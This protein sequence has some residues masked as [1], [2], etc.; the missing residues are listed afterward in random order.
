MQPLVQAVLTSW[1]IPPAA[2]FVILFTAATY[3][4]GAWLLRRA[5]YPFLPAWRIAMFLLGLFMLW[6]ALASPFDTF[7]SFF[8][9]AHMSQHMTLMMI[10]PPLL[11]LGEP[12]IPIVRG[13]PRFAARE[14][15]GPFLNW[16]LAGSI[17]KFLT[18]PGT[19]LILMGAVMFIWHVPAPYELAVRSGA[20]HE[21]EHACFFFVSIIFW[22]PVV[23]P[24]PSHPQWPRWAMVPYLVVADILNTILSAIL[25]FSEH[26]LYPSYGAGPRLFGVSAL[27]DQ[28]ASGAVM[29]TVGSFA[30]LIPAAL[31]AVECLSRKPASRSGVLPSHRAASSEEAQFR[32]T[33][34][35]LLTSGTVGRLVR[36]RT[37]EAV[38]FTLLF[39]A[40]AAIFL[41]LS[42]SHHD[43]D[44]Q[45]LRGWQQSGSF[46]I[47]LY[48]LGGQLPIGSAEFA[49]LVQDAATHTLLRD[50][51][52]VLSLRNANAE[53]AR[54]SEAELGDEN[55]L[56]FNGEVDLDSP[57]AWML[58][59]IVHHDSATAT[60]SFPMEAVIPDTHLSLP[61]QSFVILA[62]AIL[63]ALVYFRRHH[64]RRPVALAASVPQR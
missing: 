31:I 54:H 12:L 55:R 24:W 10:A 53:A 27:A 22:W 59:I 62:L 56:L 42:V 51:E 38:S 35:R 29:W 3:L 28:A 47:A 18:H 63:L 2:T 25:T 17:G 49:I 21:F 15:A 34:N 50:S 46:V 40:V 9:T 4:R 44:D 32:E 19:A 11:L 45:V 30:F 58:D 39:V 8:I 60:A 52:V 36:S 61:W 57:G 41:V 1:C 6:F 43:D 7:S 37:F 64:Q 5:G 26:L 20:W 48:G 14:F 13:M 33:T 23:Q 16:R